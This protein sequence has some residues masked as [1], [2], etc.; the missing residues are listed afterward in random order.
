M[1]KKFKNRK[2]WLMGFLFL[3][4]NEKRSMKIKKQIK[5]YRNENYSLNMYG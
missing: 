2:N 4:K 5:F 1:K 3:C